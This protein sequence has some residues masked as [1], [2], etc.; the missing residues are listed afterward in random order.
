MMHQNIERIRLRLNFT[1]T[2]TADI[3]VWSPLAEIIFIEI[4]KE[5]LDFIHKIIFPESDFLTSFVPLQQKIAANGINNSLTQLMLKAT[6][7]G[8]PDFYQGTELWDLTLVDLDNRQS[9]NY[10][11][12]EVML[13]NINERTSG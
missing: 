8:I 1:S 12:R 6:C 2:S 11:Q 9:V 4:N 10:K 7:P 3:L 5:N 13:K